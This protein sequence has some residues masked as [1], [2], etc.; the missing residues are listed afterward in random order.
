MLFHNGHNTK[1]AKRNSCHV[2]GEKAVTAQTWQRG[3]VKFFLGD[4]SLK[5]ES[6]S[7]R[8]SYVKDE[9]QRSM[10][11]TNYKLT[12]TKMSF[13]LLSHHISAMDY[14]KRL[15]FMSKLSVWVPHK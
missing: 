6:R 4:L 2:F 8:P 5:D 12:S 10:I 14:I 7:G 1:E 11:R 15:G 13:K 3:F 9:V